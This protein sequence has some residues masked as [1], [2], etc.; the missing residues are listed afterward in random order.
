MPIRYRRWYLNR[1]VRHFK[2]KN[3]AQQNASVTH[4]SETSSNADMFSR[5]E[6]QVKNKLT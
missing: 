6:K 4:N 2:E 3:E 5:F 1:L